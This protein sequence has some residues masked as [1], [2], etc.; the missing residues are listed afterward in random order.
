[1]VMSLD[2]LRDDGGGRDLGLEKRVDIASMVCLWR[3]ITKGPF[4]SFLLWRRGRCVFVVDLV[5]LVV[6]NVGLF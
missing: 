4:F 3:C 6:G 2:C 5:R 1:M